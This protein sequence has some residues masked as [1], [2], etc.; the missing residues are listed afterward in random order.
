M[1]EE[2]KQEEKTEEHKP[3][4]EAPKEGA[5]E[6]ITEKEDKI[7]EPKP[8]KEAP[9]TILKIKI[10]EKK[11]NKILGRDEINFHVSFAGFPT[12]TRLLIKEKLVALTSSKPE[13]TILMPLRTRFGSG[14]AFGSAHIYKNEDKMKKVGLHYLLVRS[15]L[16]QK[17]EKKKKKKGKGGAKAKK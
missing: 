17:K 9:K 12:P 8:K 16:A 6:K 2:Q 4:K 1:T 7:K 13:L 11:E 5:A 15:G 14:E 3:K 10:L